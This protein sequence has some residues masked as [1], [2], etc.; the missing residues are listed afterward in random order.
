MSDVTCPGGVAHCA[1]EAESAPLASAVGPLRLAAPA[2]FELW[3]I[4][5]DAS[6]SAEALGMLSASERARAER[7][8][9]PRRRARYLAARCGLR[10]ILSAR[11]GID[12]GAL[13]LREGLFGKPFL[14]SSPACAFSLS[15]SH[16]VALVALADGGEIGVDVEVFRAFAHALAL[17]ERFCTATER[18]TLAQRT[19]QERDLALLFGWT[20]KEAC[21]K[22]VGRGLTI[23]P[24]SFEVGLVPDARTVP[25]GTPDGTVPVEV[26]SLCH[27][28]RLVVSLARLVR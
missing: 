20:R 18:A 23:P 25:I 15:H 5:L 3:R 19:E 13:P 26:R 9:L 10:R 21:L 17:A 6:P 8:A 27:D 28:A 4:D 12:G 2:P 1:S 24:G 16:D 22:A 7:F 11:T 14:E